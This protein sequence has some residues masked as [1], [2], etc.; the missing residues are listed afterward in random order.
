MSEHHNGPMHC[1]RHRNLRCDIENYDSQLDMNNMRISRPVL[2]IKTY[3]ERVLTH[4]SLSLNCHVDAQR[5]DDS[6]VAGRSTFKRFH[7]YADQLCYLQPTRVS[8]HVHH[9][10]RAETETVVP[11]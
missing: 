5:G 8:F 11:N 7:R 2:N 10:D 1:R 3:S 6:A 4:R 9:W